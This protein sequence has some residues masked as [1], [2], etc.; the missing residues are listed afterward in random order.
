[1]D[2]QHTKQR[3]WDRESPISIIG[4]GLAGL[5]CAIVLARAG[6]E[7]IIREWHNAVGRRFHGDYQG[8]ENWSDKCDVLDELRGSGIAVNFDHHPVYEATAF[9]SRG[10][11]H[12]VRGER[13]L[14]YLVQRGGEDGASL[15]ASLLIQAGEAGCEIYL[16]QRVVEPQGPAVLAI[17]PRT[18]DAIAAGYVFETDMS[19]GS[20]ASFNDK[21]APLGYAYLLVHDGRGTLA[22]CMFTGFNRQADYVARSV[23]FFREHAGLTMRNPKPL[24]GF[25]NFRLPRT[26]IQGGHPVVGEQAGFQDALAGFGMRYALRS[27]ILAARSLLRGEDYTKLWRRNLLPLL[28][29]GISNRFIFNSVGAT[30]RDWALRGLGHSNSENKLRWLYRPSILSRL[31]YPIARWHYRSPLG[32]PSCNHVDCKCVW[33]E[34]GMQG[35]QTSTNEC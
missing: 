9:D 19:D 4:A 20:W 26:A 35:K 27:G 14:Y 3:V 17:G 33:C 31:V 6:Y 13:P 34:H 10:N 32:D 30:G 12:V 1:M 25:A 5:A 24:G 22:S 15:E 11:A 23:E 18:A 21:L 28:R 2:N 7:V 29:V 8:L 16:G